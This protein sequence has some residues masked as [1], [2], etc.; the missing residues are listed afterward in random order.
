MAEGK[1]DFY[2]AKADELREAAEQ[3]RFED[4][5]G[6]LLGLAGLFER[7]AARISR[8]MEAQ[9]AAAD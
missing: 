4:T 6:Q 8:R 3:A 2:K 7:L 5:R 9:E 1:G